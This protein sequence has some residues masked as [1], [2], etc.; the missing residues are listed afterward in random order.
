MLALQDI[1]CRWP[2]ATADCLRIDRL[3]VAAGRTVFLYGPSG[4]G[5]STLLGLLA[6]VLVAQRGQ[7]SLLGHDWASLPG[8]RRA[9]PTMWAWST[10]SSACSL[11]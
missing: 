8:G 5:K 9:A 4:C 6:G 7:V 1:H 10:S 3:S 11:T 2:G